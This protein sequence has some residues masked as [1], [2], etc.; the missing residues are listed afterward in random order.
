MED[1]KPSQLHTIKTLEAAK[2]IS[3]PLRLQIIEVL[4]SAPLTVKQIA[5]KLGL[6][7]SKLYYH[8][9]TLEKHGIIRVVDTTIHGNIIEKHYWVTAYNYTMD[10]DIYNFNVQE[11]E[12]KENL[13]SIALTTLDTL[14]E[15]FA[16][17]IEARAFNLEHG[18]E[19]HPRQVIQT[20][21]VCRIPDDK[22]DSFQARLRE[23]LNEF[24]A[25]D[26]PENTEVQPWALTVFLYPTFYFDNQDTDA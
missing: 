14:R 17:S 7:S 2:A 10:Q 20:R 22:M 21:E 18:A 13:I 5:N 23:L 26:D 6:A 25:L 24:E 3:D 15:D 16:R 8:V 9:N 1:I 11:P 4:L 19:P 12:G